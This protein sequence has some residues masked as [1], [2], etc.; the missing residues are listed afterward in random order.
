MKY[1]Y[2]KGICYKCKKKRGIWCKK[3]KKLIKL[4]LK[5][6]CDYGNNMEQKKYN[7]LKM[8]IYK[9]N[10]SECRYFKLKKPVDRRELDKYYCGHVKNEESECEYVSCPLGYKINTF[11]DDKNG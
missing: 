3:F 2:P 9:K 6:D 4:A 7:Y 11:K 8:K 1:G 5:I 10:F